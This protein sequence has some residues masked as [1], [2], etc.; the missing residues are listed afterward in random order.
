MGIPASHRTTIGI[1]GRWMIVG[2]D[3]SPSTEA[4]SPAA[5]SS[6]SDDAPS[7]QTI[8]DSSSGTWAEDADIRRTALDP[9]RACTASMNSVTSTSTRP[10]P[11][12][13][14]PDPDEWII[15]EDS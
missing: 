3:S 1:G 5:P 15:G 6:V 10:A 9:R 13:P 11:R 4:A 2:R 14:S 8:R 12:S 7:T